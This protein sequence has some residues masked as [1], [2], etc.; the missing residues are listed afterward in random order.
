MSFSFPVMLDLEGK[1]CL[2]IG[3]GFG[4]QQKFEGLLRA[5]AEV[6]LISSEAPEWLDRS[7]AAHVARDYQHGDL[8]GF[9]LVI[10]TLGHEKNHA[11][12]LEAEERGV[13]FNA[14]DDPQHC[15]FTYPAIHQQGDL[16]I[17]VS[18]NGKSPALASRV[19]DQIA[20]FVGPEYGR[21]LEIVGGMRRRIAEQ[22]PAFDER[23]RVWYRLVDSQARERLRNGDEQ[24][25]REVLTE[26][27]NAGINGRN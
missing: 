6:T 22:F 12:W 15:N 8:S 26:I 2:V 5:S 10:A 27:I 19:R 16:L 25:A 13:L 7:Q 9:F 23:K 21:L 1:R 11:I 18:S 24:G 3:T 17:A 4:A 20:E 14:V